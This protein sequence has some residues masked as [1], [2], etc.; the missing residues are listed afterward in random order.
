[1]GRRWKP[2][3]PASPGEGIGISSVNEAPSAKFFVH[4]TLR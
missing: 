3:M 4:G 1:M 2:E